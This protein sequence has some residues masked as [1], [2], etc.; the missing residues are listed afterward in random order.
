M[1]EKRKQIGTS[2]GATRSRIRVASSIDRILM[3]D[4]GR[5]QPSVQRRSEMAR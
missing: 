4:R 2:G 1:R 3:V 5:S